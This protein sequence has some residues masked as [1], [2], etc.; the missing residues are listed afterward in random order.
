MFNSCLLK[1]KV[2]DKKMHSLSFLYA[3]LAYLVFEFLDFNPTP[4][5]IVLAQL[6]GVVSLSV[7]R[8]LAFFSSTAL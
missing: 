6:S 1:N 5:G 8:A 4:S 2:K 3:L 7:P